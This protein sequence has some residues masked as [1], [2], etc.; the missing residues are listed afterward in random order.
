MS[1]EKKSDA[2]W[3]FVFLYCFMWAGMIGISLN[4][5]PIKFDLALAPIVGLIAVFA[6]LI[7][8]TASRFHRRTPFAFTHSTAFGNLAWHVFILTGIVFLSMLFFACAVQILVLKFHAPIFQSGCEKI[9]QRDVSLFVWEAM[10]KG[11]LKFVANYIPMPEGSCAPDPSSRVT[12]ITALVIRWF[13]A[14]VVVWYVLGLGKAW[15]ARTTNR[16]HA[17]SGA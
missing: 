5:D 15:Y 1:E 10:A 7:F 13:T 16:H 6:A 8:M 12:G 11:A 2:R 14:L 3:P 9:S 4:S 17:A